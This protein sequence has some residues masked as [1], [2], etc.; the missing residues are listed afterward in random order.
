MKKVFCFILFVF[1]L[2]PFVS[3]EADAQVMFVGTKMISLKGGIP[4]RTNPFHTK[5]SFTAGAEYAQFLKGGDYWSVGLDFGQN[6]VPQKEFF[7]SD[8]TFVVNG[9]YNL[10][11]I[12]DFTRTFNLYGFAGLSLGYDLLNKGERELPDKTPLTKTQAFIYGGKLGLHSDIYLTTQ[13]AVTLGLGS[14]FLWG[15]ATKTVVR[16]YFEGGL[17]ISFY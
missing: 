16:P 6:N 9:G 2:L 10:F 3:Q 17:K 4:Y 5:G 8:M 11:I 14:H 12:G 7:V 15:A 13:L 1:G